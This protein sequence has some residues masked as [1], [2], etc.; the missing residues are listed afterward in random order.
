VSKE[1]KAEWQRRRRNIERSEQVFD[2]TPWVQ[3]KTDYPDLF[4]HV[5][6]VRKMLEHR[7]ITVRKG[8][9]GKSYQ[10]WYKALSPHVNRTNVYKDN[11]YKPAKKHMVLYELEDLIGTMT[12]EAGG[13]LAMCGCTPESLEAVGEEIRRGLYHE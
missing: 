4:L 6:T 12:T 3:L 8:F 1:S 9:G 11:V 2:V 10:Y 7:G 5:M 13:L